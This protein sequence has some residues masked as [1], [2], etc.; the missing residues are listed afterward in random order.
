[1]ET[2]A[3]AAP[4]A[5]TT[6]DIILDNTVN[7]AGAA[8]TVTYDTNNLT[9]TGVTSDFFDVIDATQVDGITYDQALVFNVIEGTGAMIAGAR[10]TEGD[11]P[12]Q[13]IAT[14]YFEVGGS[15]SGQYSIGIQQSVINNTD[16]GYPAGGE[17]IPMLVGIDEGGADPYPAVSP[18][19][20]VVSAD[21]TIS[22]SADGDF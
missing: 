22:V 4:G 2:G 1:M 14:L 20:A 3:P 19:P 8:F 11:G 7:T 9:L 21:L 17:P 6:V 5:S 10:M 16:A 15:A 12:A 13:T 18:E